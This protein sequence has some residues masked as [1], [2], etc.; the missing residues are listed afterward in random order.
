MRASPPKNERIVVI[1]AFCPDMTLWQALLQDVR[2]AL[3]AIVEADLTQKLGRFHFQLEVSGAW[4]EL[5]KFES[6]LAVHEANVPE[7]TFF[8]YKRGDAPS[9]ELLLLPYLVQVNTLVNSEIVGLLTEF[10]NIE[11]V[12][13]QDI[14]VQRYLQSK[15]GIPL[16]L[17]TLALLLPADIHLSELRENFMIFCEQYNIDGI[18]EQDRGY[19]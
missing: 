2:F 12:Q 17:T 11:R 8:Q 4:N 19:T 16:Q 15:T 6:L 3:V 7:E 13:I 1:A 5:A 10:F 9:L 14:M 18:F